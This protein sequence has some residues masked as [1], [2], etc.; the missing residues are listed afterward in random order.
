MN[1]ISRYFIAGVTALLLTNCDSLDLEPTSSITDANYWKTADQFS[2]FNVGLAYQM[3]NLTGNFFLLGEPRANLYDNEPFSGEAPQG[4]ERLPFNTLNAQNVGISNFGGMYSVIN[5]L[6]LFISKTEETANLDDADKGY[7]L[8]AAYGMRAYLYFHLLRSWGNVIIYTD[9]TAGGTLDLSNLSKAASPASEVMNFIKSDIEASEK[10]FNGNFAFTYGREYWSLPATEILKGEVYLWSGRQMNGGSGD[11]TIALSALQGIQQNANVALMS[12]YA[13]VFA[14]ANKKNKEVIFC[15]H[16]SKDDG[17]TLMGGV[18]SGNMIPQSQFLPTYYDK[19]G[20]HF[21]S[22]LNGLI[23]LGLR[24][25]IYHKLYREDDT[26]KTNI[27]GVYQLD[28]E[29]NLQYYACFA[30][31]YPGVMLDGASTISFYD[32][33]VLYRYSD[34]LLL[35]AEAKALLGQAPTQEINQVRER[36]YGADYFAAHKAELGYPND[37]GDLYTDNTYCAADNAGALEAVL[38]ERLRE[39]IFEGK[40]WYDL[41]LLGGEFIK[42]YTLADESRLLWPIDANT[43]TNNKDLQQTEGY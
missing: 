35:I 15:L 26:R 40:R 6:N 30:N 37:N 10:A 25:D 11:Y 8:G 3:R 39:F 4:M 28:E 9:Y 22:Q 42:K 33:D 13:D 27:T 23:R 19:D 17:H 21:G 41:R 1:K 2:A 36:A 12:T 34:C 29:G 24:R 16:N 38:K 32:D 5:Q 14:F 18:Y 31:K 20:K 7:F 43:L